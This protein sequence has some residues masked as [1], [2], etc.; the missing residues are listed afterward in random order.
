M[1][2]TINEQKK[3]LQNANA[4]DLT[5]VKLH[6][7]EVDEQNLV[8]V[9][10]PKFQNRFAVKYVLPKMENKFFKI[11]LDKLGS[12]VW[13]NL[14]GKNK[15]RELINISKEEFGEEIH[16]ADERINKFLL[17]LFNNKL[18]SFSE[19]NR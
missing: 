9:L 10:T 1:P 14:N 12:F 19:V 16:P 2:L 6:P 13:L 3:I 7:E 17:Q 5:P 11:K 8:T 15:V 18:I 4:L